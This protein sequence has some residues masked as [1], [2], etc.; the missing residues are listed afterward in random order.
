M[1]KK[2]KMEKPVDRRIQKTKKILS[3]ALVALIVEKGYEAITIKDI[4]EKANV[5]R[6]TFYAHFEDKE[7]LL[8]SGHDTFK[9]LLS[10]HVVPPVNGSTVPMKE[11][12]A[13]DINFLFL[14]RHIQEQSKLTTAL[15]GE[16]GGEIVQDQVHHIFARRIAEYFGTHDL[17]EKESIL[18]SMTVQAAA[19][20]MVT[21]LVQWMERGMPFTPEEMAQQSEALLVKMMS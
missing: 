14:Y 8:L 15:L 16:K 2:I 1:K 4:I 21:L 12:H 10:D 7:Q 13:V 17:E 11:A 9:R 18:F 19:T 20:A 6:S 5:G 3:E